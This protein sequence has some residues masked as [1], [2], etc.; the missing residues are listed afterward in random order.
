MENAGEQSKKYNL[1]EEKWT[2]WEYA[3]VVW[4]GIKNAIEFVEVR[5]DVGNELNKEKENFDNRVNN[6]V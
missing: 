3:G 1:L 2:I 6:L 4:Q 5:D